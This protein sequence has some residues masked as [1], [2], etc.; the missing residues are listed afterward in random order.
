MESAKP[1]KW[2]RE[3]QPEGG[4][5]TDTEVARLRRVYETVR[6]SAA[7]AARSSFAEPGNRAIVRERDDVVHRLLVRHELL[8]LWDRHVLEVGAGHG[9]VLGSLVSLGAPPAQ[10]HGVDLLP[11]HVVEARRRRP[12]IDWRCANAEA[13]AWPDASF[14]LVLCFT[15]FSSIL[16]WRMARNVARE[17]RRVLAPGGAVVWYDLRRPN[18]WNR[19]VRAIGRGEIRVLFPDLAPTLASVTVVPA[20]ARAAGR[21]APGAYPV[22]AALPFLRT[23]W[24]GILRAA[25]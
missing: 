6:T 4:S 8:P 15:V 12:A 23:H 25:A 18:P 14:W 17:V 19:D 2:P 22:L 9:E 21:V 7:I 10:L 5:P 16:D 3:R 1:T 13:L 11:G 24:L 20:L